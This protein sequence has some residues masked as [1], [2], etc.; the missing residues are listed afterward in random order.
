MADAQALVRDRIVHPGEARAAGAPPR[1]PR[2][3]IEAEPTTAASLLQAA[4]AYAR[5]E[6]IHYY[7]GEYLPLFV[8]TLSSLNLS[9][10]AGTSSHLAFAYTNAGAAAGI[11]PLHR[12]ASHYFALA[13]ATLEEAYD[14]EVESYLRL[15][16]GVYLA[17]LAQWDRAVA[18][19]KLGQ[20]LAERLGFRR[21]WEELTAV[22]ALATRDFDE[23]LDL[24]ARTAASA[25]QRSDAQTASWGL[26]NQAEVL[27]ARGDRR[28]RRR[29]SVRSRAPCRTWGSRSRR[30]PSHSAR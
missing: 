5:L 20:D 16:H 21:R 3:W 4:R 8:A 29:A 12:T 18:S 10:R 25:T 26:L 14:V 7:R 23:R 15:G 27:L 13:Q 6:Q 24:L 22:R 17:G 2:P 1:R 28:R 19:C 9:E 11:M 30:W